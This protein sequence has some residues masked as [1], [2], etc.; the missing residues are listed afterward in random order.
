MVLNVF[1]FASLT[2][3]YFNQKTHHEQTINYYYFNDAVC[4]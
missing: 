4:I 2:K 3:I 1:I